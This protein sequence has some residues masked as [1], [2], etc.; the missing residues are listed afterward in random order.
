MTLNTARSQVTDYSKAKMLYNQGDIDGALERYREYFHDNPDTPRA[1][2][3]AE[4]MLSKEGRVDQ[5]IEVLREIMRTFDKNDVVW[6]RAAYR[7]ADVQENDLN[8][9]KTAHY[10]LGQIIK[11]APQ[12][13]EGRLAHGRLA[14]QWHEDSP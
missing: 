2:F 6:V 8:E 5:G 11:R 13:E 14:G 4:K 3:E 12:S 1:L 10:L 9:V 7:M